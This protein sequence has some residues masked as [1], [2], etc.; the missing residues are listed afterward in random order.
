[1]VYYRRNYRG[2][3][4][5][6][7]TNHFMILAWLIII[8]MIAGL[9]SWLTAQWNDR[10][11]RWIALV[12]T[13]V[14]LGLVISIGIRQ[15]LSLSDVNTTQ[16]IIDLNR[17]W[18]PSFGISFH[19]AIDGFSWLMLLLTAFL[20]VLSVL[21]SWNDIRERTGFY[22]FNLLWTLAGIT[23]VFI[24]MDLFL[25]YFFW[26]VMIVPMYFSI[27]IWGSENRTYA[28]YK[29]FLFTQ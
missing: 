10:S 12:A 16:W 18:I 17:S 20:G 7:Y 4:D 6:L 9:I 8:F 27:G 13:V 29:F 26:E 14:N 25:F 2:D 5:L 1:M 22:Y 19:L 24:A 28:S 11:S 3:S 15:D 23:G 21:C